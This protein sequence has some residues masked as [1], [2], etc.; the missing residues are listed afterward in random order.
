ML[1]LALYNA[2]LLGKGLPLVLNDLTEAVEHAIIAFFSEIFACLNLSVE[3]E[4]SPCPSR[5]EA[6]LHP[7]L[8]D[9]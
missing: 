2:M 1:L 4:C 5:L 6:L 8:D 3:C 7:G 9:V